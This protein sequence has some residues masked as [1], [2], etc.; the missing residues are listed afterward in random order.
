M[1]SNKTYSNVPQELMNCWDQKLV[2]KL[3]SEGCDQ[4]SFD[5][6]NAGQL[7]FHHS[8]P[9]SN[10]K[11]QFGYNYTASNQQINIT[12]MDSPWCLTTGEIFGFIDNMIYSCPN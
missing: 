5:G 1:S 8:V 6:G 12:L 3:Q 10:G 7:S 4:I 2:A 9:T 11:F